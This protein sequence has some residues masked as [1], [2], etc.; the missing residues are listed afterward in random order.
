[1]FLEVAPGEFEAY[2]PAEDALERAH[3]PVRRPKFELSFVGR[4]EPRE[5]IVAA[6]VEIY[7]GD[8]LR[9]AAI[10]PFGKSHHRGEF[11]DDALELRSELAEAVVRLLWQCLAVVTRDQRDDF[12]LLRFESAEVAMLDQIIRVPVM[13]L[14]ADVNA[15]VV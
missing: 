8:R 11:F 6:R 5:V 15:D 1:M 13:T 2:G 14:V 4:A 7:S 10:E 3:V 9:V 12:D